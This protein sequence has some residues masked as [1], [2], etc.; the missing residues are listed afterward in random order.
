MVY[1]ALLG[2]LEGAPGLQPV[3]FAL[4]YSNWP[5]VL[6]RPP[7]VP[8][9]FTTPGWKA[10]QEAIGGS[11]DLFRTEAWV[12]NEPFPR[13]QDLRNLYR[14]DYTSQW[15]AFLH[16]TS[17]RNLGPGNVAQALRTLTD[18]RS[19]LLELMCVVTQNTDEDGIRSEFQPVHSIVDAGSC[20][21]KLVTDR[22]R[23]Y[24]D[25]LRA[26]QA[27]YQDSSADTV[28]LS[29]TKQAAMLAA[30]RIEDG[31]QWQAA[32][33]RETQR[34][35]ESP[36]GTLPAP[37]NP[38]TEGLNSAAAMF[39]RQPL[40]SELP[41]RQG[42]SEATLSDFDAVFKPNQGSLWTGLYH[43]SGLDQ[44]LKEN[45]PDAYAVQAG[46]SVHLNNRFVSFFSRAALI[47]RA[48]YASGSMGP[49]FTYSITPYHIDG[50]RAVDLAIDGK[51]LRYEAATP[52]QF[53]WPGS[54]EGVVLA[55]TYSDGSQDM[56]VFPGVWG[57][58]KF[59][60]AADKWEPAA[61][62]YRFRWTLRPQLGREASRA[63]N[64]WLSVNPGN[65]FTE[66]PAL[67]CTPSAASR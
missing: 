13:E 61:T 59:F 31:F 48:M 25:A 60:A 38:V 24:V 4:Q 26:L 34:L 36:I 56:R 23:A 2:H 18:S 62:S 14:A 66:L 67:D 16:G 45:G 47:S 10:M 49:G 8:R 9:V 11:S 39:C 46:L 21:N 33:A 42:N 12:L 41:F 30:R 3:D 65:V 17:V 58:F 53:A 51:Q 20:R 28:E 6:T 44:V 43:A 1:H 32:S 19:P 40:L 5:S 55:V 63:Y 27:T 50:V 52:S 15:L 57:V 22:N 7:I 35:I 29:Q 37:A 54:R 64:L